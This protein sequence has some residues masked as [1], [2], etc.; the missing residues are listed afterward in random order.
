[1]SLLMGRS[2]GCKAP[3]T[4]RTCVEASPK[5]KPFGQD[6]NQT[7]AQILHVWRYLAYWDACAGSQCSPAG[8]ELALTETVYSLKV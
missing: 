7:Q 5:H 3:G 8:M 6:W 2:L 4:E 1:M